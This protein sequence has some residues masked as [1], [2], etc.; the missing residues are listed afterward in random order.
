[1]YVR[2]VREAK[3]EFNA[4]FTQNSDNE[5]KAVWSIVNVY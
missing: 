1:M 5:C 2:D 4:K 3:Y